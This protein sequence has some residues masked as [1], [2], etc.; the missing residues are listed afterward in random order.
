M[1]FLILN[2][3]LP[4]SASESNKE[5]QLAMTKLI[6]VDDEQL[7]LD[8]VSKYI[9][10]FLPEFEICG[11]F[12]DGE[13]VVSYTHLD[14]YKRQVHVNTEARRLIDISISFFHPWA[15]WEYILCL[16]G[17]SCP[18]LNSQITDSIINM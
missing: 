3:T 5:R 12:Y 4:T 11:R 9:S 10:N 8:S 7:I 14:V 1:L 15:S 2:S 16:S 18:F 17:K 13:D 6:L